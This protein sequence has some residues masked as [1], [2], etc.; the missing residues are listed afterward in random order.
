MTRRCHEITRHVIKYIEN[1]PPIS[2]G[3]LSFVSGSMGIKKNAIPISTAVRI[4]MKIARGLKKSQKV[5]FCS[6][7]KFLTL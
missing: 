7:M 6:V 2:N 3:S 4:A 5:S 1:M